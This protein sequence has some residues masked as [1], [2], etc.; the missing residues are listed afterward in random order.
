MTT[1]TATHDNLVSPGPEEQP[2]LVELDR[3]IKEILS[4]GARSAKL[5][6]AEGVEIEIPAS[7]F[8]ALELVAEG[9]AHGQTIMLIPQGKELT[10]QQAAEILHVSRPHVVKLLESGEVPFHRVGSHRRVKIEDVLAYREQRNARRREALEELIR[11]SEQ[12]PG[13]YR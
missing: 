10:T 6:S 5:V 2:E 4:T 7:A 12:A 3:Q 1:A 9:M 13:G 8:H 11:L